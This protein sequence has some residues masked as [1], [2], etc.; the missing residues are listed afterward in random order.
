[1]LKFV[2]ECHILIH[3]RVARFCACV[4]QAL[5]KMVRAFA[6]FAV[7]LCGLCFTAFRL[8]SCH[9]LLI[10]GELLWENSV[11]FIQE[12]NLLIF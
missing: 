9:T 4:S 12:M 11:I 5:T 6:L 10:D 1:M 8:M 7:M 3:K 2:I